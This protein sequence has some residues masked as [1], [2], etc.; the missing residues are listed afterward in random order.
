M[1]AMADLRVVE[2]DTAELVGAMQ[3]STD[4]RQGSG[5]RDPAESKQSALLR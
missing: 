3:A 1:A 2:T 4:V 5:V